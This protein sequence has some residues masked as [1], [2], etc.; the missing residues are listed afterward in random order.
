MKKLLIL[1]LSIS[2]FSSASEWTIFTKSNSTIPADRISAIVIDDNGN[3]WIASD[4]GLIFFNDLNWTLYTQK[5]SLLSTSVTDLLIDRA[6]STLWVATQNGVSVFDISIPSSIRFI[7]NYSKETSNLVDNSVISL[8]LTKNTHWLGTKKGLSLMSGEKW[9][10]LTR[11]DWLPHNVIKAMA[12]QADGWNFI[13]TEGGGVARIKYDD[14][15]GISSASPLVS[16]WSGIQSDTVFCAFVAKDQSRWFGTAY[17]MASHFGDESRVNWTTYSTVDGLINNYVLA[18]T[19]DSSDAIWAGTANG[20]SRFKENLWQNWDNTTLP[21][22]S[23]FDIASAQDGSLWF[24]TNSGLAHYNNPTT[25]INTSSTANSDKNHE[26]FIYPNP[27]NAGTTISFDIR[28]AG[29]LNIY[30]YNI[31]GQ[32]IKILYK[33]NST[34]SGSLFW[35]GKNDFGSI[36]PS[37]VY[38]IRFTTE[39]RQFYQKVILLK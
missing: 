7:K 1:F 25:A 26:V 37:G 4:Q 23:V 35:D 24:A 27:F 32:L 38:Y 9:E 34:G 3:K 21:G 18:I 6:E 29:N 31:H 33:N 20:V 5:D 2:A 12:A 36:V 17:G 14:V 8:G 15:D 10:T 22:D 28:E 19:Q 39:K 30:V 13:S 11:Y 16:A